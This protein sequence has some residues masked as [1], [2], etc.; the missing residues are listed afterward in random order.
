[1]EVAHSAKDFTILLASDR[2]LYSYLG[3]IKKKGWSGPGFFHLC[4]ADDEDIEHLFLH[5][6]FT[7]IV[8]GTC[9]SALNLH[10]DWSGRT[11][12]EVMEKW[13]QHKVVPK[14]LPVL[15]CWFLWMERN[16]TLFEGIKPSICR[17]IHNSLTSLSFNPAKSKQITFKSSPIE[18]INGF[19]IV[20]FDGAR[21]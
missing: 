8:W 17:L 4:R 21:P 10:L 6:Q 19:T 1:V 16:N 18:R 11:L 5:C 7:K 3:C 9:L 14:K 20:F 13:L 2:T 15:I 12:G